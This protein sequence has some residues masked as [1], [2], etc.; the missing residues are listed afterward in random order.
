MNQ[1]KKF[2]VEK[3]YKYFQALVIKLLGDLQD[4]ID[5]DGEDADY[6][7]DKCVFQIII[8]DLDRIFSQ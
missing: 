7:K 2:E 1:F 8:S 6:I 4:F 5:S 3:Y